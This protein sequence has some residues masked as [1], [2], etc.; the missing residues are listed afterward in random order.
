MTYR[1]WAWLS[2]ALA[3]ATTVVYVTLIVREGNNSFWDV[4]AWVML[5]LIGTGAAVTAALV[6]DARVSRAFALAGV[7]ILGIIG[8]VSIFSVGTGLLLA[9]AAGGLAVGERKPRAN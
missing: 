6:R 8:L 4:F 5:M 3:G 7:V 2:S 9:A 1:G